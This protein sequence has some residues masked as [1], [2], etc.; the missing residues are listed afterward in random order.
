MKTLIADKAAT[1][2]VTAATGATGAT[3]STFVEP[4]II[5]HSILTA[6][7][8]EFSVQSGIAQVTGASIIQVIGAVYF[9]VVISEKIYGLI[10]SKTGLEA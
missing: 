8:F 7:I 1:V 5:Y 9:L 4:E 3:V 10:K 2:Q 6:P